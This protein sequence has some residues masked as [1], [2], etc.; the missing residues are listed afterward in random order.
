[1]YLCE[2]YLNFE[3]V[4]RVSFLLLSLSPQ[5]LILSVVHLFHA[6]GFLEIFCDC[7]WMSSLTSESLFTCMLVWFCL[8]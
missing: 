5:V 8:L 1:M 2:L 6:V 7:G 3:N 4:F